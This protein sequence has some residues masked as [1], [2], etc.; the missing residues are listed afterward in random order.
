[1]GPFQQHPTAGI[2]HC[3]VSLVPHTK[4]GATLRKGAT[5]N[6]Y[7]HVINTMQEDAAAKLDAVF[8]DAVNTAQRR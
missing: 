7:S 1:M 3:G 8:R 2:S 6:T 5:M 4:F